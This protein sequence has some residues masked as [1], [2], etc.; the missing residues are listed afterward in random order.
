MDL[1]DDD[2]CSLTELSHR[3]ASHVDDRDFEALGALFTEDAVLVS[4]AGPRVGRAEI[5][6]AMRK[7]DRYD[8][9]FHLVGQIRCWVEPDGPHGETYCSAHHF[10]TAD[11]GTTTDH[12]LHIRYHDTYAFDPGPSAT[13]A[14]EAGWRFTR[15]EL[16]I[17]ATT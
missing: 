7:L 13:G 10:V 16:D 2:R 14:G 6:A 12:V 4:G 8:R 3:Y 5:L 11:D 15:R 1:T 9:T 17:V